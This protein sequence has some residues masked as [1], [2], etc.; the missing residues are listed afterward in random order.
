MDHAAIED[1]KAEAV[2]EAAASAAAAPV[3]LGETA[4]AVA[5]VDPVA[6]ARALFGVVVGLAEPMMPYLPTI[7]TPEKLDTLA[8]AYVPVAEKYGWNVGGWLSEFGAEIALAA[9]AVPL[10][11][12]T[13][14]AHRGHVAALAAASRPP[15]PLPQAVPAKQPEIEREAAADTGGVLRAA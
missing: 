8:A 10:A 12:Q 2:A 7:Y 3:S 15:E 1:L 4:P 9:A 13:A 14:K 11:I 6:E 5:V